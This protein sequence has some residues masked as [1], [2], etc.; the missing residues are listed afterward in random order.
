MFPKISCVYMLTNRITG[1]F[2]IGSTKNLYNRMKYYKY[3]SKHNPN[4][5]LGNDICTYGF[6]SFTVSILEECSIDVL[7]ERERFFIESFHSL[8]NGYNLTNTTTSSE[9]IT[10]FNNRAWKD[11][12]YRAKRIAA[13]RD[14]Q[15]RRLADPAY[16]AEKSEQLKQATNKMKK[17]VGM[18]SLEGELQKEF[19]GVRDAARYLVSLG[20]A[21]NEKCCAII[22]DACLPHGRHKTAYGHIWRHL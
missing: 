16:L 13:S 18:F 5:E 4:K 3:C 19:E 17:R 2:Y 7:R 14:T 15:L 11:P 1:K 20:L 22:S 6:D 9:R 8:D 10:A 21:K 12:E